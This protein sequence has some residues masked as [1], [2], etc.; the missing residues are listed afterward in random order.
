[1]H[2]AVVGGEDLVASGAQRR[3]R[4][5]QCEVLLLGRRDAQSERRR[6]RGSA[7]GSH[8]VRHRLRGAGGYLRKRLL[9]H[10]GVHKARS[11]TRSSRCTISSRPRNPNTFSISAVWLLL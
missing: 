9:I 2:I 3:G 7:D 5:L 6:P 11:K 4:R 8:D 10:T 1:T